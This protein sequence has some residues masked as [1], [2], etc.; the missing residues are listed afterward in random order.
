MSKKI[1]MILDDDLLKRLHDIQA[2][3]IKENQKS[4]S[5]SNVLNDILRKSLKL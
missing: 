5:F 1:T 3:M 2:K 4:V